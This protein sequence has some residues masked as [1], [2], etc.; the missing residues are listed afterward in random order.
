MFAYGFCVLGLVTWLWRI[1]NYTTS[2]MPLLQEHLTVGPVLRIY[3]M[4]FRFLLMDI[5]FPQVRFIFELWCF[6]AFFFFALKMQ[7]LFWGIKDAFFGQPVL[8]S[9]SFVCPFKQR[10]VSLLLNFFWR[11][12]RFGFC[13]THYFQVILDVIIFQELRGYMLKYGGRLENYFSRNR[14]THIICCNLPDS[15]IK[16]LRFTLDI[17]KEFHVKLISGFSFAC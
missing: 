13:P 14:V 12:P 8:Q 10:P 1:R 5:L 3:F 16:N 11:K 4:G 7:I 6:L 17:C 15:K 9:S 2:L